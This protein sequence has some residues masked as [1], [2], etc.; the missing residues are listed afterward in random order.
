MERLAGTLA[1]PV[2]EHDVDLEHCDPHFD[3]ILPIGGRL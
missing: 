2:I 3:K 1:P